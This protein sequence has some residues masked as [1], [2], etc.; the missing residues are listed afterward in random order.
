M[1]TKIVS[2]WHQK[3]TK[4]LDIIPCNKC[5]PGFVCITKIPKRNL[6]FFCIISV[7]IRKLNEHELKS[8]RMYKKKCCIKARP[9]TNELTCSIHFNLSL[10]A[11]ALFGLQNINLSIIVIIKIIYPLWS[12]VINGFLNSKIQHKV[13]FVVLKHFGFFYCQTM[14]FVNENVC[15]CLL[16]FRLNIHHYSIGFFFFIIIH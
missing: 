5:V 9:I 8:I 4:C 14:K 12:M 11:V 6:L 13:S 7:D 2:Q 3:K 1:K 16:R 10:I 15:F